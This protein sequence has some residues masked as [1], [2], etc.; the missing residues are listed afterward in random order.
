MLPGAAPCDRRSEKPQQ[1][2][3]QPWPL[4]PKVHPLA[5][6]L[7]S[8]SERTIPELANLVSKIRLP[9]PPPYRPPLVVVRLTTTGFFHRH[10]SCEPLPTTRSLLRV[11]E[12]CL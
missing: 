9:L 1:K 3:R 2:R 4:V 8:N 7:C 11:R 10:S 12:S 6:P 5:V